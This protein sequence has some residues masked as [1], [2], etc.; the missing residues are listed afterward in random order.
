MINCGL[1]EYVKDGTCG[2]GESRDADVQAIVQS[3]R[4]EWL[5]AFFE[6]NL[7]VEP[8]VRSLIIWQMSYKLTPSSETGLYIR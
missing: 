3:L 7:K 8:T 2:W 6:R 5:T 1:A 4:L